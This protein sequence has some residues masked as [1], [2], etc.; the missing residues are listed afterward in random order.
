[1]IRDTITE[2]I[3]ATRRALAAKFDNDIQ[4]IGEDLRRQQNE[5]NRT[6]V[7]LATRPLR[8]EPA[9]NEATDASGDGTP[10]DPGQ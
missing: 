7:R 9:T 8:V 5:S 1:M 10:H 4:R 6:F 2:G 3:R